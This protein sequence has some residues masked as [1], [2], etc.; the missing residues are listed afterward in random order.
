[1][2][3]GKSACIIKH[4]KLSDQPINQPSITHAG[5]YST[6]MS[7]FFSSQQLSSRRTLCRVVVVL[8]S[9]ARSAAQLREQKSVLQQV[10][11]PSVIRNHSQRQSVVNSITFVCSHKENIR[12]PRTVLIHACAPLHRRCPLFLLD[13]AEYRPWWN[14]CSIST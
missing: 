14:L 7:T 4:I 9:G 13:A 6:L 11:N 2:K 12:N 3:H 5:H 8:R 1:M 10:R